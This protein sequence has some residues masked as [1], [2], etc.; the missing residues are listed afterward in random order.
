MTQEQRNHKNKLKRESYHRNKERIN[1]NRRGG[2]KKPL[3]TDAE[4]KQ[5]EKEYNDMIRAKMKQQPHKVYLL[6]DYNYVGTTQW[7]SKRFSQHKYSKGWNCSNYTILFEHM[8]REECL[9]YESTMHALGY[10][11]GNNKHASYR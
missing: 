6:S 11:G 5:K 1:F 2:E 9:K 10:V 7:L 4:K 3:L 8:D